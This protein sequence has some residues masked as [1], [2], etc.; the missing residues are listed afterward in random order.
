MKYTYIP[1][2]YNV[3]KIFDNNLDDVFVDIQVA[4][5]KIFESLLSKVI[6]FKEIDKYIEESKIDIP[7]VDDF[8]YNFYHKY[9]TL[10]SKYV[11]LRNNIHIENLSD[12]ELSELRVS[13][14]L[15]F[16][17][18]KRTISKVIFEDGDLSFFGPPMDETK[19][20]SKSMVFEFAFDQKKCK[21]IEQLDLIE[22]AIQKINTYIKKNIEENLK[23][24]VSFIVYRAIPD[25]YFNDELKKIA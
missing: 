15:D 12:I 25:L 21:S 11:F 7:V 14:N 2:T 4:Y 23:I 9:S 10:G 8:D 3:K 24:P 20:S 22:N 19:V 16:D 5:R 18:L 13:E 6:N 17:F 1:D